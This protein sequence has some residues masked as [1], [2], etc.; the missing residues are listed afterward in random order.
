MASSLTNTE[1][2]TDVLDAFK[3]KFPVLSAISTD[4]SN[5]EARKGDTIRTRIHSLP[6]P[7]DYGASDGYKNGASN[8]N[9]LATDVDITLD[10]H[11]HVPIKVDYLEQISTKRDLYNEVIGNVAFALG[12]QI[13]TDIMGHVGKDQFS[14]EIA[15]TVSASDFDAL[16]SA[17]KVLNLNG[18][19]PSG[20]FGI[21]NS[22][23]FAILNKDERIASGDYHGQ[24]KGA[25]AYGV[26]NG[27]SG[28]EAIY[29]VPALP[30]N[31]QDLTG[32]FAD[33]SAIML[34]TRLP[35]DMD[36]L[37]NRLG[38]PS[39]AKTEIVS[40]ADSGLSFMGI[41][42]QDP[43][44]YDLFTTVTLLY[45]IKAGGSWTGNSADAT[46]Q[47]NRAGVRLCSSAQSNDP[48][49]AGGEGALITNTIS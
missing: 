41:T 1:V 37:A 32:F 29:E 49:Q 3:T 39:I 44:T 16:N 21:V 7:A 13:F 26:L 18:A 47:T 46:T 48:S 6:T 25:E 8:S 33:K 14:Y 36:A 30:T 9:D 27:I 22:D 5:A 15:G 38:V 34:A 45:G 2:L 12:N 28:F 24:I 10:K 20:R 19:S 43:H 17:N 40:D 35:S 42:A 31:G 4:F 23:V 11:K